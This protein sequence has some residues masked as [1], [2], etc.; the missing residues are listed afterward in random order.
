[1]KK[2]YVLIFILNLLSVKDGFS[3]SYKGDGFCFWINGSCE[4]LK[5][6]QSVFSLLKSSAKPAKPPK[7]KKIINLEIIY[8]SDLLGRFTSPGCSKKKIE[9]RSFLNLKLEIRKKRILN[10]EQGKEPP[11]VIGGGNIIAP[12]AFGNFLFSSDENASWGINLLKGVE[13]DLLGIGPFDLTGKKGNFLRYLKSGNKKSIDFVLSNIE[14]KTSTCKHIK[15][16]KIIKKGNIKLGVIVLMNKNQSRFFDEKI[17]RWL[18]IIDPVKAYK[19]I[20]KKLKKIE[21]VSGIILVSHLDISSNYPLEILKFLKNLDDFEPDLT[22]VTSSFG[23]KKTGTDYIPFIKRAKGGPIVGAAPHGKNLTLIKLSYKKTGG[24]YFIDQDKTIIKSVIPKLGLLPLKEKQQTNRIMGKFCS[25]YNKKL[26]KS[27]FKKPF[28]K[29]LFL[30]YMLSIIRLKYNGEVAVLDFNLLYDYAFPLVGN[31]TTEKIIRA[32]QNNPSVGVTK[33]KG[34]KIISLFKKGIVSKN[35]ILVLG[36]SKKGKNYFINNRKIINEQ[37]YRVITTKYISNGGGGYTGKLKS[38]SDRGEF[39]RDVIIQWFE[40]NGPGKYDNNESVNLKTDFPDFWENFIIWGGFNLGITYGSFKLYNPG[41]YTENSSLEKSNLRQLNFDFSLTSGISNR[42]HGL[43]FRGRVLYG[44][45][46]TENVLAGETTVEAES[47]DEIKGNVLYQFKWIK[48]SIGK[49]HWWA[50]VPFG[51]I[52]WSTE[53]TPGAGDER[54]KL[55]T[56]VGGIGWEIWENRLFFKLGAGGKGQFKDGVDGENTLYFGWQLTNGDLFKLFGL[57]LK[58]ESYL[59]YYI[60]KPFYGSDDF[61]HEIKINSKIYFAVTEKFF[62][63]LTH[64]F[65]G[66]RNSSKSWS[67]TSNFLIGLNFIMDGRLPVIVF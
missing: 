25:K 64:E 4:F 5:N 46:W 20:Y 30:K 10:I 67:F 52:G 43:S 40:K 38:Y 34:S 29:N 54:N 59:D 3:Q 1:M 61:S 39:L 36:L 58:G 19:K 12:D 14:C 33:I 63:N 22:L 7:V 51:D 47:S 49:G 23:A 55:G 42:N 60:S 28:S 48:N 41:V 50:P 57:K 6:K 17:N 66:Y 26:G 44:K 65:Y 18:K 37:H 21:K 27:Y 15:P 24:N 13:P 62:F 8:F 45:S 53:F 9:R 56:A 11:V 35:G 31:V 32:V 16:Y 2:M